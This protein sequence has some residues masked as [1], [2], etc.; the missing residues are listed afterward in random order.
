MGNKKNRRRRKKKW[1]NGA[2]ARRTKKNSRWKTINNTI[3][4]AQKKDDK[5]KYMK[6][7]KNKKRARSQ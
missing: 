3:K 1:E 4:P 5:G 2:T 6:M 7:E